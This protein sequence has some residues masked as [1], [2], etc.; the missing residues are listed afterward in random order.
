[1]G[2]VVTSWGRLFHSGISLGKDTF[3]WPVHQYQIPGWQ[4]MYNRK[5]GGNMTIG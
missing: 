1:M 5:G 3:V 4:A 2:A